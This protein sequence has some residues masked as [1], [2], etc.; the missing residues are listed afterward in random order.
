MKKFALVLL[1]MNVLLSG[2]SMNEQKSDSSYETEK[3]EPAK[4]EDRGQG[5]STEE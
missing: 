4:G 1:S 3:S 5:S 2:C